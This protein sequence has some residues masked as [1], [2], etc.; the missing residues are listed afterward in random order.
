MAHRALAGKAARSSPTDHELT[1]A[2]TFSTSW[3]QLDPEKDKLA[4][5]Q[6]LHASLLAPNSIVANWLLWATLAQRPDWPY[7]EDADSE[8]IEDDEAFT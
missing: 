1:L 8:D 2:G 7:P 3:E 6:L 4:V 5:W